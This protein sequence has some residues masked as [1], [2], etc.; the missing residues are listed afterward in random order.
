MKQ[1]EFGAIEVLSMKIKIKLSLTADDWQLYNIPGRN[2]AARR[3]NRAIEK[4]FAKGEIGS[5]YSV[6]DQYS[7]WGASDTEGLDT[8]YRIKD[9][10]GFDS[11]KCF[12]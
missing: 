10:V 1:R 9:A 12:A 3:I 6:L 7:E 2:L 4:K 11:D 5:C 8:L